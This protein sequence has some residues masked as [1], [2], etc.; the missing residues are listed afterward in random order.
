MAD[1]L[2]QVLPDKK[3]FTSIIT[4]WKIRDLIF[5]SSD[6]NL[7]KIA[8]E[9]AL[10]LFINNRLH[11]KAY[12]CDWQKIITG[13]SNLT[14]NGLGL[15]S[16][17]NYELNTQGNLVDFKTNIYLKTILSEATLVNCEIYNE[18]EKATKELSAVPDI[19]EIDYKSISKTSDEYLIS[20]LP[21]SMD[22]DTLFDIYSDNFS[23]ANDKEVVECAIHDIVLYN[24]NLK[25]DKNEF[26]NHLK[27]QFFKS[28]FI[29]NLMDFI[30]E[31][32]KYFGQVK[33]WIQKNCH[34]VPVPSRRDLTGNIQVLF[35]WIVELSE[36]RYLMDR[37]SYSQRIYRV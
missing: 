31:E 27:M 7:Y 13:S 33:E 17:F 8:E 1:A 15:S 6:L 32:G 36:G 11:L 24:I 29:I 23:E 4:S 34:D 9:R 2:I 12:V 21:M 30:G 22:I 35:K 14:N 19:P 5:G 37:P 10:N 26:L 3:L 25:F 18:F 20:S 28:K 16:T